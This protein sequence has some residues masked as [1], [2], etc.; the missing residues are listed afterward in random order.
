[1]NKKTPKIPYSDTL[2]EV[3]VAGLRIA[4][5][6]HLYRFSECRNEDGIVTIGR[7]NRQRIRIRDDEFV[8]KQHCVILENHHGRYEVIDLSSTNGVRIAD[9]APYI[10][11]RKKGHYPLRVGMRLRIGR[12]TLV[13][14][15]PDGEPLI[16]AARLSQIGRAALSIFGSVRALARRLGISR[17]QIEKMVTPRTHGSTNNPMNDEQQ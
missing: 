14:V 5:K 13:I 11:Y 9:R 1:M 16:A 6:K 17:R 15:G 3:P 7:T 8:S 12:T 10:R 2:P 4:G